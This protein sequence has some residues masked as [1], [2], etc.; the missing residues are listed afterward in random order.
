MTEARKVLS[1]LPIAAFVFVAAPAFAQGGYDGTWVVDVPAAGNI[2]RENYSVCPA[3]RFAIDIKDGQIRGTLHRVPTATGDV[4]VEAGN[5]RDAGP[6]TGAVQPDGTVTAV[7]MNYH[8]E[9]RLGNIY[10]TVTIKGECGPR[11]ATIIR[12]E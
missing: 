1:L 6:V 9:G 3:L 5:G 8:A 4:I 7:W 2:A 10:G 11:Q 12:V